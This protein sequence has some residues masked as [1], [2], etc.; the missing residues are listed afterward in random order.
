M[1]KH[2]LDSFAIL[3]YLHEEPGAEKVQHFLVKAI[4]DKAQLFL[5]AVNWAEIAYISKRKHGTLKWQTAAEA[6]LKLPIEIIAADLELANLASDFKAKYRLSLA[7]AFAA[8]LAKLKKAELLTGDPEFKVLEKE[9][10][11]QWI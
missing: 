2:A 3:A 6:L 5:C 11:I 4:N 7:D 1:K 9:I 10:N 8:A